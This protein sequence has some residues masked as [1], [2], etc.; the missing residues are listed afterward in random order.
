MNIEHIRDCFCCQTPLP[1]K[2]NNEIIIGCDNHNNENLTIILLHYIFKIPFTAYYL[3]NM[4]ILLLGTE[5]SSI[6]YGHIEIVD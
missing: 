6:V 3:F 5:K 2:F 1:L 4:K